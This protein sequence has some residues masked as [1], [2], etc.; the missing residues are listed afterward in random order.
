LTSP[1]GGKALRLVESGEWDGAAER[2]VAWL[3]QVATPLLEQFLTTGDAH[4]Q[5]EAEY[6]NLLYAVEHLAGSADHRQLLLVAAALVCRDASG[7]VGYGRERLAV[8]LRIDGAPDAYRCFVLEQAA[9]LL[10]RHGDHNAALEM[11]EEAVDRAREHEGAGL[12][13]RALSAL[14]YARQLRGEYAAAIAAFTPC[15]ARVRVLGQPGSTAL[16][17]NNLAWAT[18]LAGDL[19]QA[20]TLVEEALAIYAEDEESDRVAAFRHTAGLLALETG[21]LKGAEREFARSLRLVDAGNSGITPFALEGLGLA[22]I[23]SGRIER[24]LRLV[25]AAETIR[26]RSGQGRRPWWRERVTAAVARTPTLSDARV[27]AA[28]DEGRRQSAQNIVDYALRDTWKQPAAPTRLTKRE[29]D[30]VA[31]VTQ[32]LT[33]RQ[34]AEALRV[35]ERTVEAHLD[36]VRT[37]LDLRSRAQIAAWAAKHTNTD[38]G[39]ST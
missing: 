3:T 4:D 35:S 22:A 25:G 13:C 21:D 29:Q 38:R 15:L 20:S 39:S 11:A 17:L 14:G 8:A 6:D 19:A 7:I 12:L 32:G 28:L 10:A 18:V 24:G 16:C 26:R 1:R 30:V 31:L 9:W 27:R 36:H 33:N 5:L 23:H 2:L 37:K 34:I